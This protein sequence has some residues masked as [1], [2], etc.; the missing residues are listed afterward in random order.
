MTRKCACYAKQAPYYEGWEDGPG[1]LYS[2]PHPADTRRETRVFAAVS[3]WSK[4]LRGRIDIDT[5]H[6]TRRYDRAGYVGV[7]YPR[8][9]RTETRRLDAFLYR[10]QNVEY[11]Y[12]SR[13]VSAP[14]DGRI[15]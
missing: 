6:V 9:P 3:R 8:I 5:A 12:G 13:F 10:L 2:A 15:Y 7:G 11:R 1:P 14:A 4:G